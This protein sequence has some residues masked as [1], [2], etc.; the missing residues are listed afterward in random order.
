[1]RD[2]VR[3]PA[4][5]EY[6]L[7]NLK[8]EEALF[9]TKQKG[10]MFAA[11]LGRSLGGDGA[12]L[13]PGITRPGEGIRL[14]YFRSVDDAGFIRALAVAASGNLE[15]LAED[16]LEERIDIFERYAGLG[17]RELERR[18]Q[19]DSRD[20]L[21]VIIDIL[22]EFSDAESAPGGERLDR[23]KGLL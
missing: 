17:L 2:R 3:P 20:A 6:V 9:S 12:E 10:M 18:L 7:D 14:E 19:Q 16:R 23:L 13:P 1:M 8:D 22:E 5:Y 4:E 15:I 11:T 21:E